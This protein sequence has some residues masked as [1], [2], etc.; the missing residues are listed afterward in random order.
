MQ[1][2]IKR[3]TQFLNEKLNDKILYHGSPSVFKEFINKVSFF[4]DAKKFAS[5]YSDQK[6]FDGG[7]DSD[8]N[9]YTVKVNC[10]I[11]DINDASDYA[12]M[13]NKLP[14]EISYSYNNFGFDTTVKKEDFIMN[15]KGKHT[16][17][18]LENISTYEIGDE[19]PS[20]QYHLD[21]YVVLN[22]DDDFV[23]VYNKKFIEDRISKK[24]K[25]KNNKEINKFVEEFVK[26]R[27]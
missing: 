17:E 15:L 26:G 9:V 1:T 27:G 19:F 16:V 4:S 7:M 11:F 21:I 3:Y 20:P 22:K 2:Y 23:Y 8:T 10:N 18:P 24:F 25:L 13:E 14:P 6:S 5:D 12:K